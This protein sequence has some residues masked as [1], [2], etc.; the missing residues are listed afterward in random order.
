MLISL[1]CAL[2]RFAQWQHR[3]AV[4]SRC[5]AIF[6]GIQQSEQLR[7]IERANGFVGRHA[8]LTR[9]AHYLKSRSRDWFL[10]AWNRGAD[11][12]SRGYKLSD[13]DGAHI[14]GAQENQSR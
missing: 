13:S 14:M 6:R 9:N 1:L 8:T 5:G 4:V 2:F 12:E 7:H 3:F 10:V 11:E